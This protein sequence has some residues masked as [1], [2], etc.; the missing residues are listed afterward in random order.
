MKILVTGTSGFVGSELLNELRPLGHQLVIPRRSPLAVKLSVTE[1]PIKDIGSNTLW[2]RACE[3]VDVVIHMAGLAQVVKGGKSDDSLAQLREVNT[4]GTL[5]LAQHAASF[6][7]KR[8]IF[9]S[10]I[11]VLGENTYRNNPFTETD[12]PNPSDPYAVSKYEA[13]EGLRELAKNT[14]MEV[15]IVRPPLVYGVEVKGNFLKMV[16]W[17]RS[18]IPLP[19]GAIRNKR[20][21]IAVGNLVDF[22]LICMDHPRAAN[23]IFLVSDGEDLSTTDL[24]KRVAKLLGMPI[25]LFSVPMPLLVFITYLLGKETISQRLCGSLQVDISKAQELLGW[26]PPISVNEGLKLSLANLKNQ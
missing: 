5:N 11:K 24:L 6:G 10:S 4:N 20:S 22:I 2:N 26:T 8:F 13:E 25:R 19:F 12:C 15:V 3:G 17:V 7:V 16:A 9:I 14:G 23:Q 1:L 18:G 21:Q